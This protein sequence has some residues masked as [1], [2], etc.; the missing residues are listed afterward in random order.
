MIHERSPAAARVLA[1]SMHQHSRG[2]HESAASIQLL[3][4]EVN[5]VAQAPRAR[6]CGSMAEGYILTRTPYEFGSSICAPRSCLCLSGRCCL[7]LPMMLAYKTARLCLRWLAQRL[8]IKRM[9]GAAGLSNT[10]YLQDRDVSTSVG[11]RTVAWRVTS[12]R[13]L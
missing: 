5:G 12:S 4:N 13:S 8:G 6:E 10:L 3:L 7:F 11:S 9:K 1:P 2:K